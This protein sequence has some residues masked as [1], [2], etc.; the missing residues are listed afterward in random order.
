MKC[1][2]CV[3]VAT[4]KCIKK[5]VET[6]RCCRFGLLAAALWC[7]CVALFCTRDAFRV[8]CIIG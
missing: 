1:K 7:V 8:A 6:A 2:E 5:Q 4:G 3:F